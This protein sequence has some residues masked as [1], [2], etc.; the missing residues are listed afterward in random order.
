MMPPA[1]T[2][3]AAPDAAPDRLDDVRRLAR[4]AM[5]QADPHRRAELYASAASLAHEAGRH[6]WAATLATRGLA[7][8]AGDWPT[9]DTLYAVLDISSLRL[10]ERMQ[11]AS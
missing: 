4:A 2:T 5:R 11:G 8:A 6:E 10:S 1:A 3:D 9:Q 7:D